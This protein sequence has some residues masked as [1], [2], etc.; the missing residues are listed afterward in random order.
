MLSIRKTFGT[1]LVIASLFKVHA[2]QP[3]WVISGNETKIDLTSGAPRRVIPNGPDSLTFLDFS[4]FPPRVTHVLDVPNTVIGPPSNIAIT[5]DGQLALIA[6][7][8]QLDPSNTT[9]WVP[10]SYVT[11]VDLTV[12]PPRVVGRVETGL[13]PSGIS[14]RRDG[15]TALVAN[16]AAGTLSVLALHG[17]RVDHLGEV[18]VCTAAESISDVAISPDGRTVLASVQKGGYLAVLRWDGVLP[19]TTGQKIST[20][21]QPY[22]VVITP[23]GALGLT[24]G[25]GAGNRL[26]RDAL[27]VV[28]LKSQP[29]RAIDYVALGAI[30]ESFEI[31]PD[32]RWIAAVVMDGSNLPPNDPNHSNGGRL[33]MLER[34][35][36]SYQVRQSIETGRIPEGVAFTRDGRHVVVQCHADRELR[37]YE[38][39]RGKARDTGRRVTVPG[40]PSSLRASP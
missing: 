5:P 26:D 10:E 28:D 23:D 4:V 16:R 2:A 24:A 18:A 14:I 22:R 6:N 13:Q 32:G 36:G 38:L 12:Q 15:Q 39:R 25:A 3:S 7:S 40:F 20:Y 21:G 29:M 37:I 27:T 17:R 9:N 1:T 30:P 8:I 34:S 11:L 31:S 33:I 35:G 19:A